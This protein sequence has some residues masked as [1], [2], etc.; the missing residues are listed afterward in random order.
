[1]MGDMKTKAIAERDAEQVN[2]AKFSTFC[3]NTDKS[4]TKAIEE[5][6][7]M[8]EQLTADIMKAEADAKVLGE[9][10]A[11]LDGSIALAEEDKAKAKE[12][13]E[14][15]H[16]DYEATHAEYLENI[17]DLEVG[18]S[19]LK[20]MMNH[21]P[22]AAASL[23]QTLS[24]KVSNKHTKS[25]LLSF[26]AESQSSERMLAKDVGLDVTAP[27]AAVYEG[28]SGG[29]I[30]MM[31]QLQAKL[32]DEKETLE[33]EEASARHSS[34]M[35]Q[36]SLTDKIEGDTATRS[37]KVSQKKGKEQAAAEA[38]GELAETQN[39]LAEDIK[40]L[41]DLKQLFEQKKT[42]YAAR[43]E[44]RAG[45]LEALDKAIEIIS[46]GAVAGSADTHLPSFYQRGTALVQLR[47]GSKEPSQKMVAQFLQ[48]QGQ[49][50][51]SQLLAALAIRVQQDPFGKVKKMIKDMVI[52]LTEEATEEAE[53]K[54]FC[55]TELTT[56]KQTRDAKTTSVQELTAE[57]EMLTAEVAKLTAENKDLS[58]QISEID[59]AVAEA[60]ETRNAEKE[61][62]AKT[63]ADAV[64]AKAAVEQAMSV[65]K[66]FYDKAATATALSQSGPIEYDD[67]AI[68]ILS[69]ASLL[70]TGSKTRG[71]AD[72]VPGTFDKP[73][74]G[75]GGEGGILGMLEVI[76]SDFERLEEETST[77]ESTAAKDYTTFMA[78]SDEDKAVK[79]AD[80]THNSNLIT[81][82][83]SDNASAKK[84]LKSTQA[85]LDA[86]LEYYEKLKPSC[87][88]AGESYEERVQ[89][90]EDEIQSLK[91]ALKILAP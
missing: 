49:K 38:K 22:G 58:D 66:T 13:R 78:D 36:Q 64:A 20:T 5:G 12:M 55:D 35:M 14:K 44:L 60:T 2:F 62:N 31:E 15:E 23:I 70:Q 88:D 39:T 46:S 27:E 74:T 4:K 54:G 82:R 30:D 10:I 57:I 51:G 83:N 90:R 76:L 41:E 16:A 17:D 59:K 79:T 43:Q 33:K 68:H 77:S 11:A 19:K 25:A 61:K 48:A 65:L 84:D 53:H 26:L 45:E 21:A 52:K 87:V 67:R 42:D 85:E 50:M 73:F 56:N 86:A 63:I 34:D 40:Y 81:K 29:I 28:Q 6:K 1:M 69:K 3:E 91:E 18:L 7:A 37:S 32:E 89:R 75:M 47:S 24:T 8:E 9:E 72:D 80:M 71:P